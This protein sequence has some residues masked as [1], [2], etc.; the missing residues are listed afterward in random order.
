MEDKFSPHIALLNMGVMSVSLSGLLTEPVLCDFA[1]YLGVDLWTEIYQII[2]L[3]LPI[4]QTDTA[5]DRLKLQQLL[6]TS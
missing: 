2:L 6:H 3:L 1:V 4:N 5:F